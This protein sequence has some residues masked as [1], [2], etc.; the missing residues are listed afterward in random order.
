MR[1]RKFLMILFILIFMFNTSISYG[2]SEDPDISAGAAI[3]I[4]S[5]SGKILYSR[6]MDQKMYPAS[7]TKILTAILT[8]ENCNLDDVVTVPYEAISSIPSG[9]SVASLQV[10]EQLTVHQLLQV[11][12]VYSAND[13][14]NVLAYHISGSIENFAT[15]M[16]DKVAELGLENTHFTNPSGKH[17]ENHYTTAYDLSII[18]KYCMQNS[19]FRSLAGLK[20]CIIP[21]TNKYEQRVFNTTNELLIYGNTYYYKYVIAG[22]TGYTTQAKNCLVSVS[23]KDNLELISVI[24]SVGLYSDNLSAKFVDTKTLFEY[25][26]NNYTIRKLREKDAIATQIDIVNGNKETRN[27]DLLISDDITTL[28]SQDDLDTEFSPEIEIKDNLYAPI[29]QGQ[30]VG[31]ITYT[32]DD[33]KYSADLIASHSVEKSTFMTTVVQIVLI[34]LILF[35]LY[36]LLFGSDSKKKYC[37]KNYYKNIYKRK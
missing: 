31:K 35:F 12:L 24:L 6:N 28:V 20:Y 36:Q 2:L 29:S 25:G 15:L 3:L 7:T 8:L 1:V 17:D 32:I 19:T 27:L 30:V 5:S 13:A 21:A 37:K 34:V 4:D 11:L 18:M 10:G 14:A 16:N 22:K 33:I 9:Y 26:Y 23:N